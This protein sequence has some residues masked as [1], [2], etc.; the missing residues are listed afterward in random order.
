MLRE[1]EFKNYP[2]DWEIKDFICNIFPELEKSFT[3]RKNYGEYYFSSGVKV[4]LNTES[5][6]KISEEYIIEINSFSTIIKN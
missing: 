5:I 2:I 4:E 1:I 6:R 3:Q